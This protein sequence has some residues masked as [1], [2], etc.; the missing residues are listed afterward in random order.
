MVYHFNGTA[1]PGEFENRSPFMLETDAADLRKAA[2]EANQAF[3]Y[4]LWSSLIVIVGMS[5]E[6]DT[7]RGLLAALKAHEDNVPI[8]SALFVVVEPGKEALESTC[9][10]LAICFPRAGLLRVNSG[11]AEWIDAGMPELV[12]RIF[13]GE[14]EKWTF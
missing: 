10:K 12:G 1:E 7:D 4:L 13:I 3:K 5:F 11:F 8:G 14:D 6:C 9:E 2:Y